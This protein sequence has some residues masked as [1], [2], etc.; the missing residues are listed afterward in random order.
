M[1]MTKWT[2]VAVLGTVMGTCFT[3]GV[4]A[5]DVLQRVDAYLRSDFNV[6]VD[7]RKVQLANPPLIY[8]NASYLPVKELGGF[9]G[10]NVN[11]QDSTKTIYINPRINPQQPTE[12]N[13][14]NYTEIVLQYPY[15][16]YLDYRGG[17]YPVLVNT[18]DQAYYRLQ[19]LNR[20]GVKTDGLRKAK[21]KYTQDI[22]VSEEELKKIWAETPQISYLVNEP[23][24]ITGEQ[25]PLKLKTIREYVQSF[26]YYE[27]NKKPYMTSPIIIDALPELNTYSYLLT[28][29]GH[30]YRTTLKL[31]QT[32]GNN[33]TPSY[34]V[35]SSSKEDIE[36]TKVNN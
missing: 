23:I 22:Y 29:N 17:T 4:Y 33:N 20:M 7:G 31:S 21:E 34:V 1:R 5:Q 12:G 14:T 9:L 32:N 36:V 8:N 25:D 24:V 10:A 6:V 3:A 30:F 2:K 27:I 11:W 16:Q 26:R 19:D 15:P 18:T 28:E 13:E 35:G